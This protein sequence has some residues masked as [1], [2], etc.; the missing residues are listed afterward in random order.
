MIAS[1]ILVQAEAG[2][3]AVVTAARRQAPGVWEAASVVARRD[4]TAQ[5][6]I[7]DTGQLARPVT[8]RAPGTGTPAVSCPAGHR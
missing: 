5:A 6:G 8:S 3:A 2:P 4:V 7:R 1:R